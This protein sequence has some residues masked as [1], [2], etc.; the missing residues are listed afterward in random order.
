MELPELF[1]ILRGGVTFRKVRSGCAA[2][3]LNPEFEGISAGLLLELFLVPASVL[4]DAFGVTVSDLK[5][6]VREALSL[7]SFLKPLFRFGVAVCVR[8]LREGCS[9]PIFLRE[10]FWW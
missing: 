3:D 5:V 6:L 4:A 8:P 7:V 1:S 10:L 9:K 2:W